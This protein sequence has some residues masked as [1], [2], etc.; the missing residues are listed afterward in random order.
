M[1]KSAAI[2]FIFLLAS[3]SSPAQIYKGSKNSISFFSKTVMEDISA[4]DTI[5][6]MILNSKTGDV[7]AN[8]GVKGFVF[9]NALMQSHFNED[10]METD[11]AGPKDAAGKATYPNRIASFKGKINETIDYTKDGTYPVT[12]TGTL[13]IHNVAQART[14]KATLVVKGNTLTI[15]SKFNVA[16]AD[17]KIKVP[18]AV[19]TKIA[20]TIDVT[21]HS[22]LVD[23]SKK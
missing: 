11:L 4:V 18:S 6:T 1:K 7:I 2:L 13:T 3:L 23:I 9:P 16:L 14:I 21:V 15:D 19:G 17:H 8:I 20:E 12:I 22:E 5:A 10:Y